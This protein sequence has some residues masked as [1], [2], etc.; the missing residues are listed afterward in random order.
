MAGWSCALEL[1]DGRK[2]VNGTP[3]ALQEAIRRGA[4]LRIYTEFRHNEHVD[5]ASD[6][7]ELVREAAEFRTTYLVDDRWVAG[8]MTLRQPV[9]LPVGFGPRPSMSFFM[10]NEDGRQAIARPH[11]DGP[12]PSDEPGPSTVAAEPDRM[13]RYHQFDSYDFDV[14]RYWVRDDWQE[15][16]SHTENGAVLSGSV[17]ALSDAM[18]EGADLKVGIRGLCGD[19]VD[20]ESTSLDHEVFV[21]L[22][23]GYYYTEKSLFIGATHPLVRVRPAVP[24]VYASG[25]WDSGWAIVRSDGRSGSGNLNRG[26]SGIAA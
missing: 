9:E 13:P 6:S 16:L 2:P 26:I 3:A 20:N 22:N 18:S 5:A 4:D 8:I 11:L 25:G 17:D 24:I 10:Y 1:D 15:L 21:H 7:P 19:L 23:S 12:P 14:Y